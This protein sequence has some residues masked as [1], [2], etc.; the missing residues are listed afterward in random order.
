VPLTAYLTHPDRP[1][2]WVE[3]KLA[4]GEA[5]TLIGETGSPR[6]FRWRTSDERAKT[7]VGEDGTFSVQTWELGL[8]ELVSDPQREHYR[9]RVQVRHET[10]QQEGRVGV[11][12]AHSL[13]A[14][15]RVLPQ[16]KQ[17]FAFEGV[18]GHTPSEDHP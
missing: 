11:Y 17:E 10:T 7:A 18:S 5:V 14:T 13:G 9:F 8:L 16:S 12:V 6:W 15:A 1:R 2:E 4:N 3:R